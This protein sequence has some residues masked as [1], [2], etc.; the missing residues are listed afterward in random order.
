MKKISTLLFFFLLASL[1]A[2]HAQE[3]TPLILPG[4]GISEVTIG[5]K[6][7]E[8]EKVLGRPNGKYSFKEEKKGYL[9][10]GYDP[11]DYLVFKNGFDLV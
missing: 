7:S 2:F 9:N 8:V 11:N 10:F 1:N 6:M 5:M 3:K 4:K